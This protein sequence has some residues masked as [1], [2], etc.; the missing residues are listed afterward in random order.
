MS[1]LRFKIFLELREMLY[2]DLLIYFPSGSAVKKLPAVQEPQ[3][4]QL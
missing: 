3:E 2:S 1:L 4:M